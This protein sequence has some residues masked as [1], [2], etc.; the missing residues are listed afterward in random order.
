MPV[1]I[2]VSC[3]ADR[4]I[5]GKINSK[6]IFLEKLET[7]PAKYLPEIEESSDEEIIHIDLT[8][9]MDKILNQLN[10]CKVKTRLSL[11]G[12][13]I[14]ARDIAHAKILEYLDKNKD[15]PEYFKKYPVY[16]A[17][18]AKKPKGLPQVHLALQ[19]PE[20]W[21]VMYQN[22]KNLE[23]QWSCLQKETDHK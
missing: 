13:L 4:Q 9:G 2:G 3:S 11:T 22:F 5:F 16:Y 7:N 19:R 17:G 23:D 21:T 8:S 12:P 20:E 10:K 15:L 6:G 18:P 14:V 1:G